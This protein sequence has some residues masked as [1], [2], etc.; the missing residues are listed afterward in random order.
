MIFFQV[1]YSPYMVLFCVSNRGHR[2][3]L[4]I[5]QFETSQLWLSIARDAL[6][7]RWKLCG[8]R[9]LWQCVPFTGFQ[10][11]P[12]MWPGQPRAQTQ[13]LNKYRY[14]QNLQQLLVAVTSWTI[15]IQSFSCLFHDFFFGW[16]RSPASVDF[17]A[18][19]KL[20]AVGSLQPQD[21]ASYPSI[22]VWHQSTSFPQP[23]RMGQTQM[24]NECFWLGGKR[25]YD[26]FGDES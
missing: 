16:L 1:W 12:S 8:L 4:E 25:R 11:G 21:C 17:P 6:L 23:S 15:V 26:Q 19:V 13:L 18:M 9:T 5:G 20:P 3:S 24:F 2:L 10:V 14:S 22:I 7:A